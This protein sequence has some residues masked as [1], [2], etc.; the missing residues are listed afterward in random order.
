[1][2]ETMKAFICGHPIKHSRSPIIHNHW[3]KKFGID[4]HYERLDVAPEAL[5]NFLSDL[6]QNGWIGGNATLPLKELVCE[7][8]PNIDEAAAIIGAANTLWFEG[9]KLCAGNTDAYGFAANLDDLM[10]QWKSAERAMV[11]GAGG[12]SRAIIYALLA[13]GITHIDLVNRTIDRAN[14][15]AEKFGPKVHPM[16]WEDAASHIGKSDLLVNTTS[17]GMTGQPDFPDIFGNARTDA[18]A[19]DIVYI[20]LETPFIKMAA[21]RGLKTADGLGMLLHQAVPGFEK[22]FGQTPIVDAAL[23]EILL[24]DIAKD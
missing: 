6:R 5:P 13:A 7:T 12:A 17:L 10:P 22:W 14:N 3:L 23:K 21:A 15:L 18:M 2:A 4:G 9:E 8:V 20:P 1:M 19:S 11:F 24:A 16:T